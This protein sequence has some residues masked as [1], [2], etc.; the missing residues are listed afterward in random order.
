MGGHVIRLGLL[1]ACAALIV[2]CGGDD[3]PLAST[4]T[5]VGA[6]GPAA[7]PAAAATVAPPPRAVGQAQAGTLPVWLTAYAVLPWVDYVEPGRH[8]FTVSNRGAQRHTFAVIKFDGDARSLPRSANLIA[9]SQLT[10]V[11][12]TDVIEPGREVDVTVDLQ[13]GRYVLTSTFAQDYVDGMAAGFTV[14]GGASG[15]PLPRIPTDGA[16]GIYLADYGAFASNGQVRSGKTRIHVQNL[17]RGGR[18]FAVIRWRGAPDALPTLN[19]RILLDG[20]QEVYR[21]DRLLAGEAREVEVD[22]RDGFSYVF[23]SLVDG[24]YDRGVH[25]QVRVN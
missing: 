12:R 3:A 20:L 22:L 15:N 2:A 16:L 11:V 4:A 6:S 13:P 7:A 25:T 18:D 14:G 1:A 24:E 19:G 17:G 9:I 8:T 21:F 23:V 10:V 5:A